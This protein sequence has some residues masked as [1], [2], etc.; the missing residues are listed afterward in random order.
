M[1]PLVIVIFDPK[2]YALAGRVEA[3][4]L[5]PGEELLP[6]RFPKALD[7]AES[8][9]VV[10]PG[11]EV[12]RAVLLHLG[13]ETGDTTPVDVL[14]PV[15]G[16]HLFGWLVL[17]CCDSEHLQYVLRRMTAEQ[18]GSHHVAGVIIHEPDEV[19]VPAAEPE[20]EDVALP[21]LV[22]R[23]SLKETRPHQIAFGFGR[24]LNQPLLLECSPNR[25]RTG[26]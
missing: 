13:L 22:G 3:F 5:S 4:E 20:G 12:V 6:D 16:E 1:R 15:V 17:C 2:P 21:H 25:L 10:R 24:W 14:P 23:R 11:F 19:G 7:L 9:R 8:H 18:I 26:L